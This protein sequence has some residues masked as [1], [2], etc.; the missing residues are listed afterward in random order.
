MK[1]KITT[2]AIALAG[3]THCTQAENL[4]FTSSVSSSYVNSDV[5]QQASVGSEDENKTKSDT[6]LVA[7]TIAATYQGGRLNTRL[8]IRH[9]YL[10]RHV[11]SVLNTESSRSNFT[12]YSINNRIDVIK[13]A[14]SVD[15]DGEQRYGSFQSSNN[16]VDD[17]I[18][19]PDNLSRTKRLSAKFD[20]NLPRGDW[21]AIN[22]Q[23]DLS[24]LKN[25]RLNEFDEEL[26]NTNKRIVTRLSQ[27]TD[28]EALAWNLEHS[29][30]ESDGNGNNDL[31]TRRARGNV[32]FGLADEVSF[33]LTGTTES[34]NRSNDA[35]IGDIETS[36]DT[37][38]AGLSWQPHSS[39]RF[40]ITYN[41]SS[42][43][44]GETQSF[45][46]AQLNWRLS[47]RTSVQADY[48][49][50]F[51]GKSGSLTMNYNTKKLRARLTYD[52]EVT[53]FSQIVGF[54]QNVSVFVCP[55][56]ETDITACFQPDSLNYELDTGE[57]FVPFNSFTPEIS[58]ETRIRKALRGTL[59]FQRSRLS[60]NLNLRRIETDFLDSGRLQTTLL[61]GF[62]NAL[63][64]GSK[65]TINFR[66]DY[67]E[68][69]VEAEESDL[70]TETWRATLGYTYQLGRNLNYNLSYRYI[71]RSGTE[72]TDLT[73]K[74]VTLRLT[75]RFD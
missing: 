66:V 1:F 45:V 69:K 58:D 73:D 55:T 56:G 8:N 51:F 29:Y 52:E 10:D 35:T 60:S 41:K 26:N 11:S 54:D 37:Y 68:N 16:L 50:R 59:G 74:R 64:V 15:I 62:T 34:N 12:F 42:R 23:G 19:N 24:N 71:D 65:T 3:F 4:K 22:M 31:T 47:P 61:A 14:L 57:E 17:E 21:F 75:Y 9:S 39:R 30:R 32:Y 7:P 40:D 28:I 25:G 5:T 43:Q 67:Q 49:R 2:I 36:F 33:V 48:G 6:F 72:T 63:R 70:D 46:G 13:N 44:E 53:T 18:T 20:L 27:G 38:G